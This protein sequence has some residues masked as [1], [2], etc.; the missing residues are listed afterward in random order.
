MGNPSIAQWQE[1][2]NL[3]LE[4]QKLIYEKENKKQQILNGHIK[5]TYNL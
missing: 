4:E 1:E 3:K 5:L 2:E